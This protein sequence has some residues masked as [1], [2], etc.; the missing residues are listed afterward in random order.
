MESGSP[1]RRQTLDAILITNDHIDEP[2]VIKEETL[3]RIK[4]TPQP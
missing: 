3:V 1:L 4:V 2:K